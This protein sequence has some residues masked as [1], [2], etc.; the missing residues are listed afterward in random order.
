[1]RPAALALA[2]LGLAPACLSPAVS[3]VDTRPSPS[4][5]PEIDLD[6]LSAT[7]ALPLFTPSRSAPVVEPLPAPEPEA[8]PP[9]EPTPPS[10]R[11]IGVV[12]TEADP[13]AL[14]LDEG[15]GS[16][17]LRGGESYLGWT[18]RILDARSVE[19]SYEGQQQHTLTLFKQFAP[20]TPSPQTP[21]PG[22][23]GHPATP[24]TEL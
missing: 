18:L 17:R 11:L 5:L 22:E 16:V 20:D 2:L 15:G 13:I 4:A 23:M 1:M 21:P 8:P 9:P 10:L 6:S 7:R 12:G 24:E 19:F 14:L 3:Q